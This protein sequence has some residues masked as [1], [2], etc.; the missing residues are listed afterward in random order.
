MNDEDLLQN[1]TPQAMYTFIADVHVTIY[2]FPTQKPDTH[3]IAKPCCTKFII[4]AETPWCISRVSWFLFY[5][6]FQYFVPS[7]SFCQS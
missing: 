1:K 2:I 3:I 6:V 5:N 7:L 4:I